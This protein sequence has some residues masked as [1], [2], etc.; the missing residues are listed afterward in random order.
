MGHLRKP[1]PPVERLLYTVDE[2]AEALCL[3]RAT[4]YTMMRKDELKSVR[5]RDTRRIPGS[6]IKRLTES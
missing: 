6:E 3:S 5:I 2:T 4:I 1:K